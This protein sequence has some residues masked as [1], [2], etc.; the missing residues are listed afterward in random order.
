MKPEAFVAS[1]FVPELS[2]LESL[3]VVGAQTYSK[4]QPFSSSFSYE[5]DY[6]DPSPF[7]CSDDGVSGQIQTEMVCL[8]GLE[9]DFKSDFQINVINRELEKA[10]TAFSKWNTKVDNNLEH[11][12]STNFSLLRLPLAT[13]IWNSLKAGTDYEMRAM[14]QVLAAVESDRND[15]VFYVGSENFFK[16]MAEAVVN[17]IIAENKLTVGDLYKI[18][19]EAFPEASSTDADSVAGGRQRQGKLFDYLKQKYNKIEVQNNQ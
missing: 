16:E 4:T 5:G 8:D 7:L 9:T 15:I 13:G 18:M 11:S 1:L 10:Y 3:L 2:D 14:F 17:G 6:L 19:T 12:S